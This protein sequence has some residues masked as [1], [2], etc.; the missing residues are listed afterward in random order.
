METGPLINDL[1]WFMMIY[2]DLWWFTY[3][4]KLWLSILTLNS[5]MV[6]HNV[7]RTWK[8]DDIA[9]FLL[10]N[11]PSNHHLSTVSFL[12]PE[13]PNTSP[14][15]PQWVES[16]ARKVGDFALQSPCFLVSMKLYNYIYIY[17]IHITNTRSNWIEECL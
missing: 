16:S 4:Q 15:S 7:S 6:N 17:H 8:P 10:V 1:W 14:N 9:V 11:S 5:Q 13:N 12:G 2:D 3:Q